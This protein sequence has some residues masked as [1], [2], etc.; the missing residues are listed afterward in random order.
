MYSIEPS[1]A[2]GEDPAAAGDSGAERDRESHADGATGE[3]HPTVRRRELRGAEEMDAAGVGLVGD[4]DPF[5]EG[6][7]DRGGEASGGER[8]ARCLGPL[9]GRRLERSGA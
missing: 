9:A 3:G 4:D 8:P 6:G 1:D 5:A 2:E 7:A